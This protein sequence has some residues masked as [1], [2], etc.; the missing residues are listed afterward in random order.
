MWLCK[1]PKF[2][3]LLVFVVQHK[4]A[5]QTSLRVQFDNRD[6]SKVMKQT[7]QTLLEQ[8]HINAFAIAQRKQLLDFGEPDRL[9]L[10]QCKPFIESEVSAIV[11]EFYERQTSIEEIAT[12]IGDADTLQ[13]LHHA[14]KYYILELFEDYYDTEYINNRLR[15]GMVHKR[16]GVDP[17][18]YLSAVRILKE[19]I[20]EKIRTHMKDDPSL[21]KTLDSFEKMM[22]FDVTL[23]FDTYIRSLVAE[24]ETAKEYLEAHARD[25][26]EKVAERTQQLEYLS[27]TDNLTGIYNQRA[28]H[29]LLRRETKFAERSKTPLSLVYFDV[30]HFKDINDRHGHHMGDSVLKKIGGIL[31][32]I[33]RSTDFPCRYGGDEFCIIMPNATQADAITYCE[34]LICEFSIHYADT[35]LSIGIAQ[36]GTK[37]YLEPAELLRLADQ[38]MYESKKVAGFRITT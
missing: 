27:K 2:L 21:E 22:F 19:I 38:K 35:T 34:R 8:I 3:F 5:F 23:V 6:Q 32:A 11:D 1:T 13:R 29:G 25:L 26:E 12:L 17:K 33:S 20:V 36:S 14:Q 37:L 30:D 24:V 7:E 18:L 15:I 16:I 28:L 9:R 4:L 31:S 10:M